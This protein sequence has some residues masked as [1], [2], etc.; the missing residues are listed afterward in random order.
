MKKRKAV[1]YARVSTDKEEQELSLE[2]QKEYYAEYAVEQGYEFLKVYYDEGLSATNSNRKF[3][4]KMLKDAGLDSIH[5]DNNRFVFEVNHDRE[6]LFDWII[7][8][9]ASRFARNINAVDIVRALRDKDVFIEFEALGFTTEDIDWEFRLGLFL[10]FSQEESLNTSRK[11]KDAY[12]KR[13]KQGKF[14]MSVNLLGYS[15][16]K[17]TKEYYIVEEQAEIV[18]K[19]FDYYTFDKIGG[20]EISDR[21]NEQGYTTKQG[22]RWNNTSVSRVLNNEKFKGQVIQNRYG[23]TDLTGSNR[24]AINPKQDWIIHDNA[25]PKIVSVEQYDKAQKIMSSRSHITAKRHGSDKRQV[26]G[27]KIIKNVFYKKIICGKCGSDYIRETTIKKRKDKKV[28]EHYYGCRNRRN[29]QRKTEKCMNR[30]ISHDVLERELIKIGRKMNLIDL[31]DET[32]MTEEVALRDKL[33]DVDKLIKNSDKEKKEIDDKIKQIDQKIINLFDTL[34]SGV[35]S[36]IVIM[37]QER[38]EKLESEKIQLETE[39]VNLNVIELESKKKVYKSKFN[40]IIKLSKKNS[41]TFDEILNRIHE[42]EILNESKVIVK[43][44]VPTMRMEEGTKR[45]V[46]FMFE[47]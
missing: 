46:Y 18:R 10:T 26:R 33:S 36:K 42:I 29:L 41:Y 23:K 40:E 35:T 13:A 21:L 14:H 17:K 15:R 19:I 3:F 44:E 5:I 20:Y 28:T 7:I 38:I 16:D 25:L 4:M 31:D 27:K 45:L 39:K 2:S 9:D 6:P 34:S 22:R 12:L 37:T 30:G 1:V 43:F 11:L 24:R 8:K 47:R 32:M